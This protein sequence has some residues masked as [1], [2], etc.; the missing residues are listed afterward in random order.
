M[1][2]K[3]W[4]IAGLLAVGCS[5]DPQP[6]MTG[7]TLTLPITVSDPLPDD[8]GVGDS[9]GGPGTSGGAPTGDLPTGGSAE[10]SIGGS[11]DEPA[12][13]TGVTT[14]D[15][16]TDTTDAAGSSAAEESGEPPAVCGD[17]VVEGLEQCDDGNKVQTDACLSSCVPASC[18]DGL[19]QAGVEA[20]DG[21]VVAHG[22]CGFDCELACDAN[23]DDCNAA[24]GDGCEAALLT[25][26]KHCGGCQ[27]P[28]GANAKCTA[29]EC[30]GP[31]MTYGPEHTFVGLTSNH[32]VTQ[33]TCSINNGV[34]PAA[35]ADYFC[36]HF[37]S[38]NC[39]AKAG[40]VAGTTP[41]GTYPKMHKNGSCTA[42][43]ADIPGTQ[44]DG[45]PCKIGDWNEITEGLTKLICVCN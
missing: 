26:N 14:I 7:L 9:S 30:V 2:T 18:G 44:C 6:G 16:T 10:T 13:D 40:W 35:D 42:Q 41:F 8:S 11:T 38:A 29:G 24:P 28:C 36:K 5:S 39:T 37:Y 20:C 33:G 17:G 12:T 45:G 25:D 3:Y 32:Y 43:G 27:S 34:D 31:M 15:A 21:G 22:A 1:T 4:A 23:F 19:V